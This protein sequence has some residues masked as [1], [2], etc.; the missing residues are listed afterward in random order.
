MSVKRT[1]DN[2]A[3]SVVLW[4]VCLLALIFECDGHLGL[5]NM[6]S[7][8]KPSSAAYRGAAFSLLA[9]TYEGLETAPT[10]G[11]DGLASES[12]GDGRKNCALATWQMHIK[13]STSNRA[14][15]AWNAYSRCDLLGYHQQ[16]AKQTANEV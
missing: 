12:D 1:G 6:E 8:C 16:R 13:V 10:T 3:L 2:D 4:S 7:S 5:A 15:D 14:A 9:F 11:G